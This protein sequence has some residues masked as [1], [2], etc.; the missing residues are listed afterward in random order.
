MS[1]DINV[2]A[3]GCAWWFLLVIVL[4]LL[5]AGEPD[6]LD[7]ITKYVLAKSECPQ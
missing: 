1:R 7:A 4:V 3:T 6:L 2:N 5:C